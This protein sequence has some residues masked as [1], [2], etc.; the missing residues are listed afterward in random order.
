MSRSINLS[1]RGRER[2]F[3]NGAVLRVDRKVTIELLNDATFLLEAHVLQAE[4]ATTPIRQL[5]FIAQAM[6][7]DPRNA[8]R[9]RQA[10]DKVDS[11]I[12]DQ[13]RD[14]DVVTG[15]AAARTFLDTGRPFEVL[16][17]LR[18]LFEPDTSQVPDRTGV[19]THQVA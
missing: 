15:L 16:R 6:L 18:G 10:Y 17:I 2:I 7:I 9:V 1:L 19:L 4:Q 12:L 8:D 3:I 11:A 13:A 5:Y 14:D